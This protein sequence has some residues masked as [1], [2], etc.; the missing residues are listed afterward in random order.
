MVRKN[1]RRITE[2]VREFD[3][4]IPMILRIEAHS[5]SKG[6]STATLAGAAGFDPN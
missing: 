2:A 3:S 4:E 1:L 6:K 5:A